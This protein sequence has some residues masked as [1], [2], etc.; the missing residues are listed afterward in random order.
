MRELARQ[1][2]RLGALRL[3]KTQEEEAALGLVKDDDEEA[4][5]IAQREA[6]EGPEDEEPGR[7][8]DGEDGKEDEEKEAMAGAVLVSFD[9][10]PRHEDG[11]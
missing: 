8:D 6:E 1:L 5:E 4:A 11:G 2:I 3:P 10:A 9:L 7:G